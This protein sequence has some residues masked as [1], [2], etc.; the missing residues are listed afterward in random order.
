MTWNFNNERA[1]Y[2]QII[3]E[4]IIQIV[5]GKY[6]AGQKLP[7]VRELAAEI[8]VNPN[9]VQR[10]FSELESLNIIVTQRTNGRFVTE[11]QEVLDELKDNLAH[12]YVA[13][14]ILNMEQLGFDKKDIISYMEG[15]DN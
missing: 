4:L 2:L 3:D 9:T 13:E 14:F 1:I 7:A 8:K 12:K 10:A 15:Y 5:S 11:N 6:P